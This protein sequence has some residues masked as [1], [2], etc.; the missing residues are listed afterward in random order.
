V[1]RFIRPR[2]KNLAQNYNYSLKY[3]KKKQ[4]KRFNA[5]FNANFANYIWAEKREFRELFE[6]TN[7]YSAG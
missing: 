7:C 4:K 3:Q 1:P 5:D 6:L 2:A